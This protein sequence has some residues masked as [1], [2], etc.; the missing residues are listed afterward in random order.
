M[1]HRLLTEEN[2]TDQNMASYQILTSE[3]SQ[4]LIGTARNN[5]IDDKGAS[6]D[7]SVGGKC[8]AGLIWVISM[9]LICCTLPF[10]LFVCI[11]IV[12]V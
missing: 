7:E 10:S 3:S 5:D 9:I 8:V 12:Q 1:T 2:T 11:R 6:D 4:P